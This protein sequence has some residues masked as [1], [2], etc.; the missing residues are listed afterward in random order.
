MPVREVVS[1]GFTDSE[2]EQAKD[3]VSADD[4]KKLRKNT[5]HKKKVEADVD[6]IIKLCYE[7]DRDKAELP[8]FAAISIIVFPHFPLE[9]LDCG[10]AVDLSSEFN[11]KCPERYCVRKPTALV[12]I[13]GQCWR[14]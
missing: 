2:I 8:R 6:D 13:V 3:L 9:E 4:R 14:G 12:L 10:L 5:R 1:R 7:A 11:L